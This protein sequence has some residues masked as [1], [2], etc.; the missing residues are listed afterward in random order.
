MTQSILPLAI[1]LEQEQRLTFTRFDND[2][3]I[4]LGLHL[5][6]R[7]RRAGHEIAVDVTR[8]HHQL[9]RASLPGTSLDNDRWIERKRAVVY[10]FGHSSL[11]MRRLCD[12]Q[13]L[14]LTSRYQLDPAAFADFGGAFPIVV[15][16]VGMVG[17]ATVSGLPHEIDHA[18]VVETLESFLTLDVV[19]LQAAT[20]SRP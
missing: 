5:L 18:F 7:A 8:C 17:T 12:E 4:D 11:Y 10:R 20:P 3:A 2:V 19:A 16:R 9:F 6:E 1:L 14:E 15:E 13:G